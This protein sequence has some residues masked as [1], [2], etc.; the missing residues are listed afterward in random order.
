[1]LLK[2]PEILPTLYHLNFV[3]NFPIP[4]L[5]PAILERVSLL[6]RTHRL[7]AIE[8]HSQAHQ[9]RA[10]TRLRLTD[11]YPFA[12]DRLPISLKPHLVSS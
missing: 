11:V 9:M 5:N 1:M 10:L 8:M 4:Y 6:T 7:V 12:V 3:L 2:I